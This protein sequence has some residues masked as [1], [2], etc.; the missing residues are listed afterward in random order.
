MTGTA[1]PSNGHFIEQ[2][3]PSPKGGE[4]TSDVVTHPDYEQAAELMIKR[5]GTEMA[6]LEGLETT[7]TNQGMSPDEARDTVDRTVADMIGA[8][9]SDNESMEGLPEALFTGVVEIGRP[10]QQL[11]TAERVNEVCVDDP[12]L[13][14]TTLE[15]A[16]LGGIDIREVTGELD[17]AE[18]NRIPKVEVVERTSGKIPYE[19][20]YLAR[21]TGEKLDT[22][23][24]EVL[25]LLEVPTEERVGTEVLTSDGTSHKPVID[26]S[27]D[28]KDVEFIREAI[29]RRNK[30]LAQMEDFLSSMSDDMDSETIWRQMDAILLEYDFIRPDGPGSKLG[31]VADLYISSDDIDRMRKIEKS[32]KAH[33]ETNN[34]S[35]NIISKQIDRIVDLPM[36]MFCSGSIMTHASPVRNWDVIQ[37]AGGLL[38]RAMQSAEMKAGDNGS[39]EEGHGVTGGFVHFCADSTVAQEYGYDNKSLF[40]IQVDRIIEKTPYL[41]LEP[42][43]M[44]ADNGLKTGTADMAGAK[45]HRYKDDMI[46][47]SL[48]MG[49]IRLGE[50]GKE[51]PSFIGDRIADSARRGISGFADTDIQQGRR[52]NFTFAASMDKDTAAAYQYDMDDMVYA[53]ESI[54]RENSDVRVEV[55]T[56]EVF[57]PVEYQQTDFAEQSPEL[58]E[59]GIARYQRTL[60]NMR[61]FTDRYI[62][63][64][65]TEFIE[66][67]TPEEVFSQLA[68]YAEFS[69]EL[70]GGVKY[71]SDGTELGQYLMNEL[72]VNYCLRNIKNVAHDK[73][74]VIRE[75]E[76]IDKKF[77]IV[78][79]N[80]KRLLSE[81]ETYE[82]LAS[83][84]LSGITSEDDVYLSYAGRLLRNDDNA[85][86]ALAE[87]KQSVADKV[88]TLPPEIRDEIIY[89]VS[90]HDEI[91]AS[92]LSSDEAT[93]MLERL[94][95]TEDERQ[96]A[97][98]RH[99]QRQQQEYEQHQP[100]ST[101]AKDAFDNNYS[102]MEY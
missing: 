74:N 93:K 42:G 14:R 34:F 82:S 47:A 45:S 30:G 22:Y 87:L 101:D 90:F 12:E 62:K 69:D 77:Q 39:T 51:L 88:R 52:N 98:Q 38:P 55:N 73:K 44:I 78:S 72:G 2:V 81:G 48:K 21:P 54:G 61:H 76:I 85:L 49:K 26:I 35:V 16:E 63:E 11:K 95:F 33:D 19:N 70:A 86:P 91:A 41:F 17:I 28:D 50:H 24:Q 83:E 64:H 102:M 92:Y 60:D 57:M 23:R 37:K 31:T 6:A 9:S 25:G 20:E 5:V 32:L 53:T 68:W 100:S 59:V 71:T 89:G 96:T 3:S 65:A 67:G 43:F 13:C 18:K 84:A 7:Y 36:T 27:V 75:D 40:G 1:K 79:N 8:I 4:V 46:A 97:R 56:R 99:E 66:S 15:D 10:D 58:N 80:I 29:G 94:P